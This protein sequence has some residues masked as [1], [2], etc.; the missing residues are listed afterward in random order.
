MPNSDE[1]HT[2]VWEAEASS[3][4][5]SSSNPFADLS[6]AKALDAASQLIETAAYNLAN[7]LS[8]ED[9]VELVQISTRI[10]EFAAELSRECG[11]S[12]HLAS[13]RH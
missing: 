9:T 7:R 3:E 10:A 8:Q 5:E 4:T 1:N 2:P 12:S 6:D 11:P 13:T